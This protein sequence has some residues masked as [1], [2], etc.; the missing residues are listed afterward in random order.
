MIRAW[1]EKRLEP[2]LKNHVDLVKLLGIADLK[3][4]I[5]ETAFVQSLKARWFSYIEH[6]VVYL[7]CYNLVGALIGFQFTTLILIY[8]FNSI[9]I[10]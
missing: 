6:V 4:G 9:N 10:L 2:K 5:E 7:R 1:G 3:K 8:I